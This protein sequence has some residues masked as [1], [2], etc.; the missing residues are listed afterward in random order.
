VLLE[1]VLSKEDQFMVKPVPEGMHSLT[2]QLTVEGAGEAIEFYKKAFGAVEL[3]RA[4]DP[5]G[6]KIWHAAVKIGDSIFYINDV[7]PE[8]GGKAQ[9]ATLWFYTPGV[10]AAF[11]RAA[12][13]GATV[14]MPI[15]DMFWGDRVGMVTD[16]WGNNWSLAERKKDLTREEM[17]KAGEEFAASMN[18]QK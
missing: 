4:P 15:D 6:Q 9:T 11:K 16:R 8:M 5:S 10:D 14:T 17:K 18:Q 2:P 12:D 13:A 1:H 7:F 3:D